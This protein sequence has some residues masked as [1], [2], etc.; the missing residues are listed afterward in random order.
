MRVVDTPDWQRN[1]ARAQ[2]LLA[3]VATGVAD[4]TVDI[5]ANTETIV[6][7]ASGVIP[8]ADVVA[9]GATSGQLY[10]G[11][12]INE[13]YSGTRYQTSYI[14]VAP[15]VDDKV[16]ISYNTAPIDA[17]YVFSDDGVHVVA[18]IVMQYAIAAPGHAAPGQAIEVAG[19][20]GTDGR[21]LRTDTAG[22]LWAHPAVPA[23]GSGDHPMVEVSYIQHW[24][25][26]FPVTIVPAPPAG[27]RIRLLGASLTSDTSGLVVAFY[28]MGN[29]ALFGTCAGVGNALVPIPDQGIPVSEA[30]GVAMGLLAGGSGSGGGTVFYVLETV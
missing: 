28:D 30:A 12:H 3:T 6:I 16:T 22:T 17:W 20:D 5:P 11:V 27:E 2:K 21:F 23:T 4:V 24:G 26:T 1:A 15:A 8:D 29:D 13:T 25:S 14:D 18:D 7:M 19:T 10:V 9:K